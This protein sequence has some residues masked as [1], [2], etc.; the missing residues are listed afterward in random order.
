MPKPID[1][2]MLKRNPQVDLGKL[3]EIPKASR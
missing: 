2:D 3:E 1:V